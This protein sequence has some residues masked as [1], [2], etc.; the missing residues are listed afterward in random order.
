MSQ[1]E[2]TNNSEHILSF[3]YEIIYSELYVNFNKNI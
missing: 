1:A 2:N 3:K